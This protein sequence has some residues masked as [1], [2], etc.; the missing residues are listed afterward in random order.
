VDVTL[1]FYD[2]LCGLCNRLVRFLLQ[3]DT[4]NALKFAQLQGDYAQREL[5]PHGYDPRDLD[6]VIVI[7]GWQSERQRILTKSRAILHATRQLGGVWS[8]LARIAMLVPAPISD[9]IYDVVA[10]RRY[11]VFGR[12]D[13]CPVPR[14]E[15]RE[16]FLDQR[17]PGS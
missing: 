11:H 7:A 16:R 2:G 14:A 17:G 3:R 15:W 1:V 13:A 8:I 4:R 5:V 12:L 6:T 9:G 10:R